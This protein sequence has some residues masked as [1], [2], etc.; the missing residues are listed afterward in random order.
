ML[1][2]IDQALLKN[3]L[4]GL[5]KANTRKLD[6]NDIIRI[7]PSGTPLDTITA[8]LYHLAKR[9]FVTLFNR[10]VIGTGEVFITKAQLT[11]EGF[12]FAVDNGLPI[13]DVTIQLDAD[14][15]NELLIAK[16]QSS[17]VNPTAD[18]DLINKL[19]V[20]PGDAVKKILLSGFEKGIASIPNITNWANNILSNM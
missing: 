12:D 1:N 15:I 11:N 14:T 18:T 19:K 3:L 7:A 20:L 8:H 4:S 13:G 10:K 6:I 5:A 17:G 2:I 9:G 16:I